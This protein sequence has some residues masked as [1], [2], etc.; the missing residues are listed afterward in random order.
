[1]Y[2]DEDEEPLPPSQYDPELTRIRSPQ[3]QEQ[4]DIGWLDKIA[5]DKAILTPQATSKNMMVTLPK[6]EKVKIAVMVRDPRDGSVFMTP[7]GMP[8][9]NIEEHNVQTGYEAK[10]VRLPG[11]EVFNI[12]LNSTF[13]EPADV[14]AIR[15]AI[16]LYMDL[17]L[18]TLAGKER[19][20]DMHYLYGRIMAV[21][22]TAKSRHGRT[23]ELSK[24]TISKGTTEQAIIQQFKA[25]EKRNRW[26]P[27]KGSQ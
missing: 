14:A 25:E 20:E 26:M 19:I 15:S 3:T 7:K 18:Q 1:M 11:Q 2:E 5:V 17:Q 16:A 27:L 12:D 8:Y 24:T 22:E 10:Q 23:A 4:I 6:I 13:L 9:Y 21:V